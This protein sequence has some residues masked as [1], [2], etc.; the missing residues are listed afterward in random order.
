M[1]EQQQN[2]PKV[3]QQKGSEADDDKPFSIRR[4]VLA[5]RHK[6]IFHSWPF[7]EKY[8]QICLNHGL[9]DILPPFESLKV[10][11]HVIKQ[12]QHNIKNEC[13][14]LS[15]GGEGS[16]K[17]VTK[18]S[19]SKHVSNCSDYVKLSGSADHMFNLPSS[20]IHGRKRLPSLVSSKATKDK[21]RK[22]KGRCKKRSMVD[23]LAVARH[24]TLEEICRINKFC[25]TTETVTE[26]Y[27][28][29]DIS[30]S[31][32]RGEDLVRKGHEAAITDIKGKGR[33][34]VKF[35]LNTCNVNR[36]IN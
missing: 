11:Q 2:L 7:P 33:L 16:Y 12:N 22:R 3:L 17:L 27:Q 35:K 25:Y 23:I 6:S 13:D 10:Q 1:S 4:Y 20:S 15:H 36:N 26:A 5:S 34:L 19:S 30:K 14:L 9:K 32:A 18:E 24:C 28:H 31:G 21:C 29:Q 8:L